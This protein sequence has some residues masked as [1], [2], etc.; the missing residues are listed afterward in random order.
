[1]SY[2]IKYLNWLTLILIIGFVSYIGYRLAAGQGFL[3]RT[4]QAAV[5]QEMRSLNRLETSAFTI[6]KIIEAGTQGN[7]FEDFLFGDRLLL[8]AHGNVIAGV[9]L[10]QLESSAVKINEGQLIVQLP[11]TEIFITDL[12]ET[13]TRVY[14]RQQGLLTRGERNLEGVARQAAEEEIRKAACEAG[15][16]TKAAENA[17]TQLTTF[18][19]A[20]DFSQVTVEVTPG[21]C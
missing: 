21:N 6:E 16:L 12:D 20:L 1:M 17:K 9:D 4:D 8:I 2:F 19:N 15:I 7:A 3:I 13:K 18:L 14:D 5:V 11:P 10:S